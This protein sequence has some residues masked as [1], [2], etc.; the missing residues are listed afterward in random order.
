MTSVTVAEGC[1]PCLWDNECES[2]SCVAMSLVGED[3][4]RSLLEGVDRACIFP[5]QRESEQRT[6]SEEEASLKERKA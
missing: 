2:L 5:D 3:L 6:R 1:F 4:S